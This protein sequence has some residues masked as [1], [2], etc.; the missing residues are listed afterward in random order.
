[1]KKHILIGITGSIAAFKIAQL[2]S[3]LVKLDYHVDVIMT[4]NATQFIA[5]MTFETLTK[6]KVYVDTFEREETFDVKH[7]SLAKQAD[8]VLVA[9][10]SANVIAKMAHGLADDMLTSTLLACTCPI[11]VAPAMNVHMYENPVTQRNITL[12]KELK[13]QI[14]EPTTGRL[15]CGDQGNGKLAPLPD[16]LQ[17]IEIALSDK[18]LLGKKVLISAGPTI[19]SIDPVRFISN[20]SSGKMG[21]H[22][23]QQAKAMGADVTLVSG[24][25]SLEAPYGVHIIDVTSALDM[26]EAIKKQAPQQDIIIKA[27][28]VGDYR[29]TIYTTEK[30]KKKGETLSIEC[31]QNPDILAYLGEHKKDHQ[32]LCGF[33]MET[34]NL[35]EHA[36]QKLKDKHCDLLIANN[37]FEEG[38]GFQKDTN[39][40]TI[41]KKDSYQKLP[42]L[43]KKELSRSILYEIIAL[44]EEKNVS[45]H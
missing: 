14:I 33:A 44:M 10:A 17:A 30:I 39:V 32:I 27:A 42:M 19:E 29:P 28:A 2:V 16:L 37:L 31:T 1:M 9:P 36:T 7:I 18:P 43:S 26:F 5:P 15:A 22:L 6:H 25:V 35:L 24:P 12:L 23:A 13:I 3:D 41:I 34:E 11:L 40:V 8:V 38:A 4:K 20:H 21:Y 45:C